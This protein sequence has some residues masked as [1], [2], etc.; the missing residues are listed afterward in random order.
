M[1]DFIPLAAVQTHLIDTAIGDRNSGLCEDIANSLFDSIHPELTVDQI[2]EIMDQIE[3]LRHEAHLI[4][5]EVLHALAQHHGDGADAEQQLQDALATSFGTEQPISAEPI[6]QA[7]MEYLRQCL[8]CNVVKNPV[9]DLRSRD[10]SKLER[11]IVCLGKFEPGENCMTLPCKC[12][13]VFH[14]ECIEKCLLSKNECITCRKTFEDTLNT[15]PV[16]IAKKLYTEIKSSPGLLDLLMEMLDQDIFDL[17]LVLPMFPEIQFIKDA[18]MAAGYQSYPAGAGM[19]ENMVYLL[20]EN[21][22]AMNKRFQK[23]LSSEK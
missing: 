8:E 16:G 7:L 4:R 20:D 11:C 18:F 3:F 19:G 17:S 6:T 15:I 2:Q 5:M 10:V 9:F 1:A 12:G 22:R 23:A 14:P 21:D 13:T